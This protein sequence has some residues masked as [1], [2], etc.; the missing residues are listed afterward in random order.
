MIDLFL[1]GGLAFMLPLLAASIVVVAIAIERGIRFRRLR[2]SYDAFLIEMRRQLHHHGVAAARQLAENTTGPVARVWREG[3]VAH[4][5]PLPL[6]R[7]RMEAV[8]L[9]EVAGLER[10][11]GHLSIIGQLAP[12]VGILGTVVGMI[13]TFRVL[14]GGL[15]AGGG[16][17][18]ELLVG[19]IWQALITTVGG[20]LVA[21][22]AL[23]AH[24]VLLGRVDQFS[25]EMEQSVA[26]LVSCLIP[27]RA[28]AAA[29]V[30]GES[31]M[32]RK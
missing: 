24:H 32:E 9:R 19:G 20:L 14:E 12:L 13:A 3:L 1:R 31:L 26:D 17:E 15:G 21:I 6:V 11:I 29:P 10:H 8:S 22:P 30:R 16:I 25:D 23:L 5:L 4:R 27:L 28:R 7:E 18:G 2:L